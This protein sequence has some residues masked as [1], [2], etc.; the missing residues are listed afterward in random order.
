MTD[1]F[2]GEVGIMHMIANEMKFFVGVVD[3]LGL[4]NKGST[5]I[6]SDSET[7]MKWIT[8]EAQGKS[9]HIL[10]RHQDLK[11]K[12]ELGEVHPNKV[13]GTENRSDLMTKLLSGRDTRRYDYDVLGYGL[14]E[15]L[16]ITGTLKKDKDYCFMSSMAPQS[17]VICYMQRN[18][19]R[20]DG[21]KRDSAAEEAATDDLLNGLVQEIV[22]RQAASSN[23]DSA[24][25]EQDQA[26]AA[27]A[28]RQSEAER[29]R[30]MA[31]SLLRHENLHRVHR[32]TITGESFAQAWDAEQEAEETH[33]AR[34]VAE[35][36]MRVENEPFAAALADAYDCRRVVFHPARIR[37]EV[38]YH[39]EVLVE[40]LEPVL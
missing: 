28:P 19:R 25:E 21:V 26:E 31:D 14:V 15:H 33:E 35:A 11:D 32:R 40:F 4:P 30:A 8:S 16:P 39:N 6:N 22:D 13:L 5:I 9:K 1:I 24:L 18:T 2:Q 29:Q 23:A 37:H 10:L 27:L 12:V 20:G 36:N 38:A 34:I 7:S 17:D 3:E